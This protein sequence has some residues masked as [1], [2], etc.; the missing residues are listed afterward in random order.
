MPITCQI[1]NR[2]FNTMITNSHAKSHDMTTK[3]YKEKFGPDSM[4]SQEF[5]DK[6]KAESMGE[7]NHMYG[8]NHTQEVKD[9]ISRNNQGPNLKLRGRPFSEEHKKKISENAKARWEDPVFRAAN[10]GKV[11]SAETRAKQSASLTGRKIDPAIT[12]R[13]VAARMANYFPGSRKGKYQPTE[14]T[15]EKIKE[16]AAARSKIL[17]TERKK[18]LVSSLVSNKFEFVSEDESSFT[19]K[20]DTCDTVSTRSKITSFTGRKV[21]S[22]WCRTCVPKLRGVAQ[23]RLHGLIQDVIGRSLESNNRTILGGKELD[24]YDP[25]SRVAVEYCGLYWHSSAIT[26]DP[27]KH[28]DKQL[29]CE[30]LGIRLITVFEDEFIDRPDVVV[31]RIAAS[32]GHPNTRV[33]A[34]K[35]EI[36]ELTPKVAN[37]FLNQYHLQGSGRSNTRFGLFYANELISVMT[38]SESN[39][40]RGIT[41][42]EINRYCTK[43]GITVVGGASKLFQKFRNTIKPSKVI[44]YSDNRWGDGSV[45]GNLGFTKDSF[46]QPNYCYVDGQI[47]IH[48]YTLRKN[49]ADDQSKTEWENR[50]DQGYL[51]VWDCGHTKWI[52]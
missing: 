41:D 15:K 21:N 35:C 43:V 47:R 2:E 13:A 12:K 27:R 32:M 45:Y 9:F 48:R 11:M 17:L 33:F 52:L 23:A 6:R 42:W 16:K 25:A 49:E 44:S 10:S 39:I 1:C 20:C 28:L 30:S 51:R 26:D 4:S 36:K 19:F 34:R 5:R 31:S 8:K 46:G 40:S 37:E 50:V 7:K 24:I 29:A 3:E 22:T 38:F 14:E 18:K